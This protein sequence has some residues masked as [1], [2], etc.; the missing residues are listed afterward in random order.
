MTLVE[1]LKSIKANWNDYYAF[2]WSPPL[3]SNV[4]LKRTEVKPNGEKLKKY[5]SFQTLFSD[6]INNVP[7]HIICQ[8]S[9]SARVDRE[10]KRTRERE[11]STSIWESASIFPVFCLSFSFSFSLNDEFIYNGL[12]ASHAK[13]NGRIIDRSEISAEHRRFIVPSSSPSSSQWIYAQWRRNG[14]GNA[15]DKQRLR[16]QYAPSIEW[17]HPSERWQQL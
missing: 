8:C 15:A 7:C 17:R 3:S 4:I 13:P 9:H 11:F 5:T 10:W 14:R 16:Q 6:K 1:V 2:G 12:S